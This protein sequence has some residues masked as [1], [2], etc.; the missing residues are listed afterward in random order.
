ML[1]FEKG[2]TD[3]ELRQ[4]DLE[5]GLLQALAGLGKKK[6]VLILPPDF[7]RSHS[8]A[9]ELTRTAYTHYQK[10]VSAIMPA[11]G[12]HPPMTP[13][14]RSIM[15]KGI[16]AGLF[17]QHDWRNEVV[18]LGYVPSGYVEEVT[19]GRFPYAWP[20]QVNRILAHGGYDLVLSVGQVVPHEV[21]G[22]ANYNKN[23]LIGIGGAESIHAS[24]FMGAVFGMER[25]MGRMDTPVRRVLNYAEKE[26]LK[27]IPLVYVLTVIENRGTYGSV[28]RGL[29]IGD[30]DECFKKAAELSAKVN[31]TA[32]DKPL[33]TVVVYLDP[34]KYKS[35]WLCNKSI[36]R[37]RM[38]L[39]DEGRLIV[40]AP[41][42]HCFAEDPELDTLIRKYGYN[43]TTKI[44]RYVAENPDLKN[45]LAVAAHLIHG[46]S[47]GRFAIVYCPGFL[48]R[49]EMT[50]V[51]FSYESLE[52]MQEMYNPAAL[53][54]GI[55]IL[56]SGEEV[57]YIDDPGMGLWTCKH[58]D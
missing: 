12:T 46:S 44:L 51:N 36:Y 6:K 30:D 33:S 45:N 58:S 25:I 15:F 11:T 52:S 35:A 8:M 38:A 22:M 5:Q 57:Y 14:E 23:V 40:L 54:Y 56:P 29:Y 24:H 13:E 41:G 4:K 37:T 47:E 19:G 49:H 31:I 3:L 50:S 32:L 1:L 26:F 42:M 55:N 21:T 7:T 39:A 9:G 27:T 10:A 16:P 43:G 28:V 53:H 17:Y 18:H 48:T 34:K 20:V 2:S